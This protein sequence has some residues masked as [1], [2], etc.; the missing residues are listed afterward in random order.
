MLASFCRVA[1][2]FNKH[3]E[4]DEDA[5][6]RWLQRFIDSK[7]GVYAGSGGI[8]EGHTLTWEELKRIYEISVSACKGKV[9]VYANTSLTH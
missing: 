7:T 6:R 8:G 9:P 2:A 4:I 3:N 5:H 1:T